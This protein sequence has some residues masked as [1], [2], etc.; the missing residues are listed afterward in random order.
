MANLTETYRAMNTIL[1]KTNPNFGAKGWKIA[2]VV[3]NKFI[4]PYH[5]ESVIDYGCGKNTLA[6][7]L[8]HKYNYKKMVGWDPGNTV[9]SD[10][11]V[12]EAHYE[13]LVCSDVLEHIE[14]EYLDNVL[15]EIYNLANVY[16]LRIALCPSNK[17]LPDGRNAHLIIESSE[18]WNKKL[19]EVGFV[20]RE[21]LE[22][23]RTSTDPKLVFYTV[24]A[25]KAR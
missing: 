2:D 19:T 24:V 6:M 14:P 20:I 25:T 22:S 7:Q 18:W 11:E 4:G 16:F 15:K 12:L 21:E 5:L 17:D 13:G 9:Y 10:R 8:E 23:E 1:H 3:Y